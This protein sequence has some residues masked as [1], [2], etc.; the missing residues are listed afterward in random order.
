MTELIIRSAHCAGPPTVEFSEHLNKVVGTTAESLRA[1]L[2]HGPGLCKVGAE[3]ASGSFAFPVLGAAGREQE[4]DCRRMESLVEEQRRGPVPPLVDGAGCGR[5]P[6][7][8]FDSVYHP[9]GHVGEHLRHAAA[10]AQ[11]PQPGISEL[12]EAG[13][14]PSEE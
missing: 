14:R 12:C 3:P 4:I 6:N 11:R 2:D 1:V 9:R 10:A 5:G 7:Q 8:R 13:A